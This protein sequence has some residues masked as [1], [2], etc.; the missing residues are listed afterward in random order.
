MLPGEPDRSREIFFWN[1]SEKGRPVNRTALVKLAKKSEALLKWSLFAVD[2]DVAKT[3]GF[4]AAFEA[5]A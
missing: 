3:G 2:A 4:L 5:A 1:R